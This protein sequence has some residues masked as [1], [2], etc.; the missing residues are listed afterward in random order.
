MTDDKNEVG[1]LLMVKCHRAAVEVSKGSR[2]DTLIMQMGRAAQGEEEGGAPT[3]DSTPRSY[4]LSVATG[5][6][7][8]P[9]SV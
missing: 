5:G 7:F 8:K 9:S 6:P 3:A 2:A 4:V 1:Q